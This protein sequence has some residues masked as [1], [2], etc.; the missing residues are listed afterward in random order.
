[1]TCN[2]AAAWNDSPK[3]EVGYSFQSNSKDEVRHLSK[4]YNVSMLIGV[5]E[6]KGTQPQQK[7][8]FGKDPNNPK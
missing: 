5:E 4:N 7:Y 3:I 6:T 1:M 8:K 2:S